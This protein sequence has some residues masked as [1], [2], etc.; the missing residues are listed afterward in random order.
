MTSAGASVGLRV[1]NAGAA[2]AV[3]AASLRS[4]RFEG[5][6]APPAHHL[7]E[8]AHRHWNTGL[9]AAQAAAQQVSD[10]IPVRL[11]AGFKLAPLWA[12]SGAGLG[13]FFVA[14]EL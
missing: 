14:V 13:H 7:G 11:T 12:A 5:E 6:R 8:A 2:A 9:A 10:T 3:V 4:D 1:H